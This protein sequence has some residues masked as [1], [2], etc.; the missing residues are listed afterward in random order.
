M[1]NGEHAWPS[2]Q[3]IG[4]CPSIKSTTIPQNRDGLWGKPTSEA[5]SHC[6]HPIQRPWGGSAL[7]GDPDSQNIGSRRNLKIQIFGDEVAENFEN[8]GFWGKIDAFVI[9]WGKF[10]RVLINIVFLN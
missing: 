8:K 9:F 4:A 6:P 5:A 3:L 2:G 1:A 7:L 10:G